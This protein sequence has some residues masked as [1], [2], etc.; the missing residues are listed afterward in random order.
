MPKCE[1]VK[2]VLSLLH[3]QIIYR[4]FMYICKIIAGAE[5]V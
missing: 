3:I 1:N 2:N 5:S 4:M